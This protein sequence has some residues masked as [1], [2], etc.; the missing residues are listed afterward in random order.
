MHLFLNNLNHIL[1]LKNLTKA[2]MLR[3]VPRTCTPHQHIFHILHQAPVYVITEVF[4]SAATSILKSHAKSIEI[5][6]KGGKTIN[7]QA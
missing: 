6:K 5:K 2:T 1:I 3:V 7:S 4:N